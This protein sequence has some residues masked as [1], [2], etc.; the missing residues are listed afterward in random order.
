LAQRR[1]ALEGFKAGKYRVLVATDIAARG[2]DVTG[3]ELVINY[4]LPDED[5]N[6]I[7]RVGRTGRAGQPGR[8]ITFAAPDQGRDVR[9]IERLMR[10]Q[11][12]VSVHPDIMPA[13]FGFS[14][15][16]SRRQQGD[17]RR[18]TAPQQSLPKPL[19]GQVSH[20]PEPD[21]KNYNRAI[22]SQSPA[23]QQR[24]PQGR[25]NFSHRPGRPHADGRRRGRS[26]APRQESFNS[27]RSGSQGRPEQRR[28]GGVG[29]SARP[30][31]DRP[32][33]NR[34]GV[35]PS[36]NSRIVS[37]SPYFDSE[38]PRRRPQP[39]GRQV[40]HAPAARSP[41]AGNWFSRFLKKKKNDYKNE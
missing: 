36:R 13:S 12:P 9:N 31:G 41:V 21:E 22:E 19:P 37:P 33:P 2:I 24:P 17:K 29:Y 28:D 35:D 34:Y 38:E 16:G 27:G 6:Y 39:R 26:G 5:E 14:H 3:I 23:R 32:G 4:D 7:H 40:T 11:L 25:G 10:M 1:E 30:S 15:N 20:L 18:P 8:A